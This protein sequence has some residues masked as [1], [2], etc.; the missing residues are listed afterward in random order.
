MGRTKIRATI[1]ETPNR[2]LNLKSGRYEV[3]HLKEDFQNRGTSYSLKKPIA[4]GKKRK[5]TG[6]TAVQKESNGDGQQYSLDCRKRA[7][8]YSLKMPLA[9][10]K[11]RKYTGSTA[12]QSSF[13]MVNESKGDGQQYSH[14]LN[15]ME[16][17]HGSDVMKQPLGSWVSSSATIS[18]DELNNPVI[19]RCVKLGDVEIVKEIESVVYLKEHSG[20]EVRLD[21]TILFADVGEADRSRL[22]Q[23]FVQRPDTF[24]RMG[25]LGSF[26]VRFALESFSR[27]WGMLESTKIG[28]LSKEE[29]DDLLKSFG[30][31]QRCLIKTD[32]LEAK[33]K[34]M[35]GLKK[36]KLERIDKLKT[37]NTER[38]KA[39]S[40]IE[41]LKVL[42][43]KAEEK[44]HKLD[45][46]AQALGANSEE[47]ISLEWS[48][49][50]GLFAGE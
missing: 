22:L 11:K 21:P 45:E 37:I 38:E 34:R 31:M 29:L 18:G 50:E 35:G 14:D 3:N 7:T 10:G 41:E 48:V 36:A 13:N 2:R 12:V 32:W 4:D 1:A 40:E 5:N 20:E 47:D 8:Q 44:K 19:V 17:S 27:M 49:V 30:D 24:M 39:R 6:S 25:S 42:L 15:V 23:V 33:L 46:E 43:S 26:F 9:D 16:Q 28:D